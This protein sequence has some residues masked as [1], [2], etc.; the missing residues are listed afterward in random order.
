MAKSAARLERE[1]RVRKRRE[2]QNRALSWEAMQRRGECADCGLRVTLENRPVWDWDHR[3]PTLKSD[4]VSRLIYRTA[5]KLLIE[6]D[7]CDLRCANC[8]R[9][10][11]VRQSHHLLGRRDGR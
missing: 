3:D 9:I 2:K 11:T 4:S 1:R 8:H 7:K 5:T 10:R 6:I